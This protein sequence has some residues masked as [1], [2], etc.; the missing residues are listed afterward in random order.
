MNTLF[1]TRSSITKHCSAHSHDA[2]EV[3][4]CLTGSFTITIDNIGRSM[5]IGDVIVIPPGTVH[6]EDTDD[7]YSD[8]YVQAKTLDFFDL[9]IVHDDGTILTLINMIHKILTEKEYNYANIADC[10]LDTIC[11]YIKKLRSV[12]SR[13]S[14]VDMLKNVIYNNISNPHFDLASEIDKTGFNSDYLRRCFKRELGMTPLGYLTHLRIDQAKTMLIQD[15]FVSVENVSAQCGFNDSF[16]FST[17]FKKHEGV[18][19]LQ[20]RKANRL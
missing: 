11:Q 20:Y 1:C 12:V 17:C 13:N 2:W 10:I 14:A 4:L 6:K 7:F 8:V 3:I 16:Y 9:F 19:P 15:T 18:S 5:N